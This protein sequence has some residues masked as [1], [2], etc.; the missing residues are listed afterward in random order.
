MPRF[1]RRNPHAIVF[2]SPIEFV[3]MAAIYHDLAFEAA[4]QFEGFEEYMSRI[5]ILTAAPSCSR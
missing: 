4:R 3:S 2:E 5:V 1:S